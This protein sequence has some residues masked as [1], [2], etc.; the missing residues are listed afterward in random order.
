MP[1]VFLTSIALFGTLVIALVPAAAQ[2]AQEAASPIRLLVGFG[3]GAP[4]QFARLMAEGL[5]ERLGCPVEV[6]NRPGR[7]SATAAE[8]VARAAPDGTTLG[9]ATS[10]FAAIRHTIRDLSIDPRTD[11]TP[12]SQFA[13]FA[14]IAL[15]SPDHPARDVRGL[16]EALKASP[17]PRC[18]TTDVASFT[19]LAG[20]LLVRAL[21]ASC[22]VVEH[23]VLAAALVELR[24]GRADVLFTPTAAGLQL[25]REGQARALAVLSRQRLTAAPEIAAAAETLPGFEAEAWFGLVGPRGLPAPILTRLERAAID[26]AR[27]PGIMARVRALGAEPVGSTGAELAARLRYDDARL[28]EVARTAG[29]TAR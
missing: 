5:R 9:F 20:M 12:V 24:A 11:I 18:T 25:V 19:H 28:G 10:S 29:V 3:P 27:D 14:P 17:N 22:G 1:R 2:P 8:E 4:D 15:V 7:S 6:E 13:A 21:G 23:R 26:V 16:A